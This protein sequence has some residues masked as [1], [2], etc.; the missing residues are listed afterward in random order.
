MKQSPTGQRG[1]QS[2]RAGHRKSKADLWLWLGGLALIGMALGTWWLGGRQSR[3]AD[4]GA[5]S[6]LSTQDFHSLAYSPIE[7][8]TVYFGHHGGLL[9]SRDGGHTWQPTTLQNADAMA[10]AMPPAGPD[11]MY[12]AGHNVFFKSQDGGQ[13]WQ[14]VL[15]NLPGLDI[16]GFAA[17]P[18]D[19]ERVYA[20][21]VGYGVFGSLDGGTTWALL[22]GNLLNSTFN[23]AVGDI[24]GVLYAAAGQAGLWRSKDDGHTWSPVE[25]L[26]GAGAIAVSFDHTRG[27]L[28]VTTAGS[29]AGLKVSDDGGE[30]WQ[31]I[32]S[33]GTFPAMAVSPLDPDRLI[34]VDQD[35]W[36]YASPNGGATWP[37]D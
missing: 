3:A 20:H 15:T 7:P 2:A 11:T 28:Y 12:A 5:I 23:L 10:L 8:N 36:V 17:D 25:S 35:G 9:V 29:D 30:S 13:T 24:T 27:R 37:S 31:P 4:T 1:N 26:S 16:H 18:T 22:S 19:A 33:P 32:G 14:S 34:I 6:R 21:I